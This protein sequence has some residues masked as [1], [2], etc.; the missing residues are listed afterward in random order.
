MKRVHPDDVE[1]T[2][3]DLNNNFPSITGVIVYY[4]IFKSAPSKDDRL[5]HLL[6]PK[7]DVEGLHTSNPTVSQKVG[8]ES[9]ND[10]FMDSVLHSPFSTVFPCTALSVLKILQSIPD[11]YFPTRTI[12]V[13]NRSDIFGKPLANI[14]SQH[15][16]TIYSIDEHDIL[17]YQQSNI[18]K[19]STTS[20]ECVQQSSIII[21]AVPTSSFCIPSSWIQPNS[22]VINVSYFD[23][24]DESTI[25]DIP[26]VTYVPCI[27]K[28]TI[29]VLEH[30]LIKL[31]SKYHSNIPFKLS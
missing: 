14:L 19:C 3:N 15:G 4:P 28:V 16:A 17:L 22:V 23:N 21:T 18:T 13:F 27:G 8:H 30:N 9:T 24:V 29:A 7:L 26:N 5:R 2:V 31:H 20:K 25:S 1:D 6:S 11:I 10:N 12:T